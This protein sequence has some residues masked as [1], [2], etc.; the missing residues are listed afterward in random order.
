MNRLFKGL[1]FLLLV[2]VAMAQEIKVITYN[3]R[4]DV[5]SDGVNQ[6]GKR[7]GSI[8][9]LLEKSNPDILCIQEG[10][11][12][13]MNDLQNMLPD[14]FYVGVGRED[15]DKKG[16]FSAIFF[17][18]NKFDLI[19]SNTF[20]LSPTP[21]IPGSKGWDAAITR[22]C[23]YGQVKIKS[24]GKSLFVFNTHFD[25]IGVK[26]RKASAKLIIQKV[27]EIAK[28]E[29]VILTGDLNSDPSTKAFKTIVKNRVHPLKESF[30]KSDK[31]DCTFS[32]FEVASTKC[33]HIDFIF[34]DRIFE[35]RNY[36]IIT[37]NNGLYYPSDHMPV[38]SILMLN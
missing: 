24:S 9:S 23:S 11:F 4:L 35:Q 7:I 8:K 30:V 21:E 19:S 20:W 16:E 29:A 1:L 34:Y 10:L 28:D 31:R 36:Q 26:A 33:K 37:D 14:Y 5:A 13:Q 2:N 15:G 25:H 27:A 3:I 18:K 17:R 6:W 12:N 32:G 38:E 22:I